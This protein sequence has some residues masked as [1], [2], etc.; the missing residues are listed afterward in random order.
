YQNDWAGHSNVKYTL[1]DK[2][3]PV[4]VYYYVLKYANNRIKQGGVYLER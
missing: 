3:L 1:G 4:G 2:P